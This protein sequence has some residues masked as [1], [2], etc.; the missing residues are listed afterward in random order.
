MSSTDREAGDSRLPVEKRLT[1][2]NVRLFRETDKYRR[3]QG[4]SPKDALMPSGLLGPVGLEFGS[5]QE[6][7]F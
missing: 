3:F 4:F 1:R 5:R 2:S 7:R 6:A